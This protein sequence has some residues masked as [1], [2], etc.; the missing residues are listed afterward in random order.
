MNKKRLIVIVALVLVVLA[1]AGVLAYVIA[2]DKNGVNNPGAQYGVGADGYGASVNPNE[3]LGTVKV[4]TKDQVN[5]G[6]GSDATVSKPEESGTLHLGDVKGETATFAVKT[7][8]GDVSF[9]VDVRTYPSA[10]DLNAAGPFTGAEQ[11]KVAGLSSEAHYLVP[12][13]QEMLNDQQVAL[14]TT[15]DKT[16]YKF[17]IVQSSDK[18]IYGTDEAKAI[19]LEIAKKANLS[20]VK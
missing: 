16:S 2:H 5:A 3:H 17:A 13:G 8:K 9:E 11:A 6:F 10:E 12:Y 7:T 20:E 18:I 15:K 14:L 4:L 1:G 19:L